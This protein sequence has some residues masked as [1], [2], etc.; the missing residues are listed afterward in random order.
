[1]MIQLTR[2]RA[3]LQGPQTGPSLRPGKRDW[4]DS[5]EGSG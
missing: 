3:G 5:E 2:S 4:S 1:M